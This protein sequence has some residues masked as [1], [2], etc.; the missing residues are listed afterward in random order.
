MKGLDPAHKGVKHFTGVAVSLC[1]GTAGLHR[2]DIVI[3]DCT[4]SLYINP[5]KTYLTDARY[6]EMI[7]KVKANL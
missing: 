4:V 6:A 5:R 1:D 2:R 3:T 7:E